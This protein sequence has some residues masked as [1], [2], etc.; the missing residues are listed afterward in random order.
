M[1]LQNQSEYIKRKCELIKHFLS[2]PDTELI[3]LQHDFMAIIDEATLAI[4]I[5]QYVLKNTQLANLLIQNQEQHHF[6]KPSS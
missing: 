3:Q 5:I 2:I 6:F 4:N 1:N